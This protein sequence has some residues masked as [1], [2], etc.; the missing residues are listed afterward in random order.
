[1]S[2]S[3]FTAYFLILFSATILPGP[4]MLLAI[5]HGVNHGFVRTMYSGMGNLFGNLLM[6][7]VSVMGLGALLL[8][9]GL[10][11]NVVKWIGIIYLVYAGVRLLI[12]PVNNGEAQVHASANRDRST[13]RLFIDG[14]VIAIGNPKGI[15]FFT[16]LF[17]QFI[18][19]ESATLSEFSIIFVT[20]GLVAFGCYM[21]Y[22]LFGA[23]LSRIFRMKRVRK[24]ANQITGSIFIGSGLALALSRK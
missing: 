1:M 7:L 18:H 4:S 9:S 15:L 6:A 3:F 23:K 20:L 2:I 11:F 8:A 5:N 12:D 16:A 21:L 13:R 17:P 22:A 19:V 24:L 14:F 10:L